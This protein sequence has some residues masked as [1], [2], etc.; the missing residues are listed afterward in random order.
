MYGYTH[1]VFKHVFSAFGDKVKY[2][3]YDVYLS[4]LLIIVKFTQVC[5][6]LCQTQIRREGRRG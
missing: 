5:M 2:V 4:P 3:S 1:N 6:N